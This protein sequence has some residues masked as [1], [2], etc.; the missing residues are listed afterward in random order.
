MEFNEELTGQTMTSPNDVTA[1]GASSVNVNEP[2]M[3]P[4][5]EAPVVLHVDTVVGQ[6]QCTVTDVTS[7]TAEPFIPELAGPPTAMHLS[8][9]HI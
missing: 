8:L 2:L 6:P 5:S 7:P 1:A 3:Q 9:I 4:V